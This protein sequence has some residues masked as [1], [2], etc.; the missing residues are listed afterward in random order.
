VI[1]SILDYLLHS[2]EYQAGL[3]SFTTV[4]FVLA[5]MLTLRPQVFV[6]RKQLGEMQGARTLD[7]V[8]GVMLVLTFAYNTIFFLYSLEVG[9]LGG[10]F[11]CVVLGPFYYRLVGEY[12][13][14]A[15]IVQPLEWVAILGS[16]VVTILALVMPSAGW[17]YKVISFACLVGVG[18]Q[19]FV[20]Y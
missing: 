1:Q 9:M 11:N 5:V 10:L 8:S 3:W 19:P 18:S 4:G 14:R 12:W 13:R 20:M 6:V 2:K 7:G 15:E 16:M 17:S